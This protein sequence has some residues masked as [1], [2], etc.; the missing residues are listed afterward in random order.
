MKETYSCLYL[1]QVNLTQRLESAF[2]YFKY[3]YSRIQIYIWKNFVCWTELKFYLTDFMRL[4][5]VAG[6]HSPSDSGYRNTLSL[7]VSPLWYDKYNDNW[8]VTFPD[9]QKQVWRSTYPSPP[10]QLMLRLNGQAELRAP[11]GAVRTRLVI[12][13]HHWPV[14]GHFYLIKHET[15]PVDRKTTCF[16]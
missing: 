8:D 5:S 16:Y 11:P 14:Q 12:V 6:P 2:R 10:H 3:I 13:D 1:M 15:I 7:L 9:K 4:Y